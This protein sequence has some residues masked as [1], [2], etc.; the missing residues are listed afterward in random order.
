MK[1]GS[2]N[3]RGMGDLKKRKSIFNYVKS[4][5]SDVIFMQ[6]THAATKEMEFKWDNEW[7]SKVH[8]SRAPNTAS[9][10][11]AILFKNKLKPNNVKMLCDDAGRFLIL[12]CEI[13]DIKFTF[14]NIYAPNRDTPEFFLNVIRAIENIEDV[15]QLIIGGD[16]NLVIDPCLDRHHSTHNNHDSVVILK[17]YLERKMLVDAWRL[18]NPDV[19]R[20]TWHRNK[21]LTAS[22]IDMIF[23]PCDLLDLID[24]CEISPAVRTDHSYVDI[25]IKITQTVRGPGFWKLNNL[26]LVESEYCQGIRESI[27]AA[28]QETP[29]SDPY[30]IWTAIKIKC[31][32]FSKSYGRM[33]SKYLKNELDNLCKSKQF[34]QEEL[35]NSVDSVDQNAIIEAIERIDNDIKTHDLRKTNASMFRSRCNWVKNGEVSSKYFFNLEKRNYMSK[36]MR[37]VIR[38]TGEVSY[39]QGIILEEQTKFYKSLYAKD[40]NVQFCINRH[41]NDPMLSPEFRDRCE[42]ELNVHEI[43][44]AVMTLKPNKVGGPD[45]FTA[46]FYKTFFHQLKNHLLRMYLFAF[47]KGLLPRTTRKGLISLLPKK[48]KDSRYVKNMRPLT[49]LNIDYKILAKAMDNRLQEV[50]PLLI[51]SDQ[52]GFMAGRHIV[53]NIRKSLDIMEYCKNTCTPAVIMSIDME[54]CFDRIDHQAIFS[55]LKLYNFG[56]NFIRWCSL[57]YNKFMV[58]TQNQGHRSQWF[59]KTRS[60]NQGCNISPGIFLLVGELLALRLRQNA[61]I[62]GIKIG[63]TEFLISQF[64]DDMD[65]YL[66]FNKTVLDSVINVLTHIEENTGLRVSYEKTTLY[67]IGSIANSEAKIYTQKELNWSNDVI[68]TLGFELRHKDIEKNLDAVMLKMESVSQMWYYRQLTLT[69]KVLIVN[70]LIGS[71]YVYK[72]QL[73]HAISNQHFQEIE[74]CIQNFI[75]KGKRPKLSLSILMQPKDQGGLGLVNLRYKHKSLLIKWVQIARQNASIK[76]LANASLGYDLDLL[77]RANLN[78]KDCNK[79][80]PKGNFWATVLSHWCEANYHEP[81]SAE[82]VEEQ[83]LWFNFMIWIDGRPAFFPRAKNAGLLYVNQIWDPATERIK[84]HSVIVNE[85]GTC[86]TWL[87]YAALCQAIPDYWKFLLCNT[88]LSDEYVSL[89]EELDNKKFARIVYFRLASSKSAITDSMRKW[90][91]MLPEEVNFDLHREAF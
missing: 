74:A 53:T 69:G 23:V 4:K 10:G 83:Q 47:D 16:F 34:L 35:Y 65:L 72:M 64:A 76:T 39:D 82:L 20:Y 9:G 32:D 58:C 7:G 84:Q 15:G 33:R 51:H 14:V 22:C 52:T 48:G 71:L 18:R 81:Q 86:I 13:E 56:K 5:N 29:R 43:Y 42:A 1:V 59:Y 2:L 40:N 21:Q 36:N 54:K 19:K 6:E 88:N 28:V 61:N 55:V 63:T 26:F 68:N 85:F 37:C 66:P 70:S 49:L 60:V 38:D 90:T 78:K 73:L 30:E 50:T 25:S 89:Y 12:E 79:L 46:E 75:W 41:P 77:I 62:T 11:V 31:T 44:D 87:E 67:R 8:H 3:V 80:F 45:G 91:K 57:F 24:D 27:E 17:E